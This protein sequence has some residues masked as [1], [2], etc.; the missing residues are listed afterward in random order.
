MSPSPRMEA[1]N[2]WT[3]SSGSPHNL[4]TTPA[5]PRIFPPDTSSDLLCDAPG[6]AVVG[7]PR[8]DER[9]LAG[10]RCISAPHHPD[11][12]YRSSLNDMRVFRPGVR[13]LSG[14]ALRLIPCLRDSRTGHA[15]RDHALRRALADGAAGTSATRRT[16]SALLDRPRNISGRRGRRYGPRATK[17]R[18]RRRS[19]SGST[20]STPRS[21]TGDRR[22]SG[23]SGARSRAPSRDGG[24]AR[25]EVFVSTKGGY[26]PHDAEDPRDPRRYIL[27]TFVDSGLAPRS[28]DRPGRPLHGA[29]LSARPDRAQPREPRPRDDRPLLPAQHR[30]AA[31]VGRPGD[32]PRGALE[33]AV[34][35]LE[36]AASEG[37]IGAWGL[38]T[39]DGLRVPPE[40][41][42]HLSLDATFEIAREVG[43]EEHHFAAVQLPVN[44]AMA[45]AIAYPSQETEG[46]TGAGPDPPRRG[47]TS[48][49]SAR[50]RSCRAGFPADL[51]E[52]IVEAF[53]GARPPGASGRSSSRA[54]PRE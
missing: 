40:H 16:R 11:A 21:T 33:A 10:T 14:L 3:R 31:D 36:E 1:T 39:W 15:G 47:S 43:G 48:R 32:L 23:R 51:P 18:S 53:P 44:L 13:E 50:R 29:G 27:E 5:V 6:I 28:R 49:P 34:E 17:P 2:R 46:G 42:E 35:A 24:A 19:G 30:V 12:K 45:Q 20:S 37:K 25:D 7:L 52:E 9:S 8:P 22:A 4:R 54:P 41:P 26:L 38:A